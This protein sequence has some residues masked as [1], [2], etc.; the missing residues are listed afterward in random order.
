MRETFQFA[1]KWEEKRVYRRFFRSSFRYASLSTMNIK[2][3]KTT[4]TIIGNHN[5]SAG[6]R[7]AF[8]GGNDRICRRSR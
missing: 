7:N 1:A 2:T 3:P 8:A 6:C 5:A 4:A